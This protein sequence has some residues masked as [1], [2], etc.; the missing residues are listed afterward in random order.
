MSSTWDSVDRPGEYL[1]WA[2]SVSAL[3]MLVNPVDVLEWNLDKVHQRE[4]GAAGIPVIP[5]TWVAPG[6]AFNP[7]EHSEFV[8][9]PSVSAGGRN[10]ARYAAGDEAAVEHVRRLQASGQ[11]VMVQDYL[12]AIDTDGETDLVFLAGEFSHAVLKKPTLRPGEGVIDRPWERMAWSGL[13]IPSAEQSE[14]ATLTMGVVSRRLGVQPVY[15]RVDL[16]NGIAGEPLLLEVE[17]IDPYLSLDMKPAAAA[18]LAD[19]LLRS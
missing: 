2:R 8:V 11:I 13:T 6:D 19:A 18:R 10:T 4:L 12:P 7:P 5:T 3:S 15:A 1:D 14:R 16:I 9:K 17:L